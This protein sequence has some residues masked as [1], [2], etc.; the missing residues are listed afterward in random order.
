M[1]AGYASDLKAAVDL[2]YAARFF[3]DMIVDFGELGPHDKL[4]PTGTAVLSANLHKEYVAYLA[5]GRSV[6][7]NL[8][9]SSGP[10][11]VTWYNP[12]TG[13]LHTGPKVDGRSARIFSAPDTNDWVLH[14]VLARPKEK[15]SSGVID[16]PSN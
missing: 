11:A 13:E 16:G 1:G 6:M 10:F 8:R 9:H 5:A 14:L 7:V 4:V 12:R 2:G 3:R 15:A